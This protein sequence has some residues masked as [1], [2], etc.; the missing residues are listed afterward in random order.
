MAIDCIDINLDETPEGNTGDWWDSPLGWDRWLSALNSRGDR[1][2]VHICC[3]AGRLRDRLTY[4][5]TYQIT[6]TGSTVDRL[7]IMCGNIGSR[8][9]SSVSQDSWWFVGSRPDP[10]RRRE[11]QGVNLL[12]ITSDHISIEG[13]KAKN[14]ADVME[15][16]TAIQ[17]SALMNCIFQ[18]A[19]FGARFRETVTD[20][21]I[22]SI[23]GKN[24]TKSLLMFY[25]N[26]TN[27]T[28]SNITS[29]NANIEDGEAIGI[30]LLGGNN[31][32]VKI[33]DVVIGGQHDHYIA[34]RPKNPYHDGSEYA[35]YN[36]GEALA[37]EGG[38]GIEIDRFSVFN[39][40]DR[41]IDCKAQCVIRDSGGSMSKR[42]ITM[43]SDNSHA[44]N[45]VVKSSVGVGNT[46]A[47][48]YLLFGTDST[49]EDCHAFMLHRRMKCTIL[50]SHGKHIKIIRGEYI[51]PSDL[52]FVVAGS[53]QGIDADTVVELIDVEINGKKYNQTLT[54][55][56]P[57]EE[58]VPD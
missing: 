12:E 15:F 38:T 53:D 5:N 27:T 18:N 47:T 6:A 54:F 23:V 13:V 49:L 26:V 19:N 33:R 39:T 46:P 7:Y 20:M 14:Y 50:V 25:K 35:P 24:I 55:Q 8:F 36:Q 58:W 57:N 21:E 31:Q 22:D 42:G 52:P 56:N 34:E 1:D 43:W 48:A 29:L 28:I 10:M 16:K 9:E 44:I 41:L 17:D 30:R 32:N 51:Q 2:L 4:E 11:W 40:T 3:D 45:C 37:I